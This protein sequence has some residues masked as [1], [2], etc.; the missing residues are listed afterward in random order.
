MQDLLRM[1]DTIST[2]HACTVYDGDGNFPFR[3]DEAR[4]ALMIKILNYELIY[5][6]TQ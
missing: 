2:K 6:K 1:C 4:E 3:R 5:I